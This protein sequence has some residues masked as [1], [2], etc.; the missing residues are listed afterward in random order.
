[1][2]AL[3]TETLQVSKTVM[4][5]VALVSIFHVPEHLISYK[6]KRTVLSLRNNY[7]AH[8]QVVLVSMTRL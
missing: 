7:Y 8:E 1:M 6:H 4:L 2:D 5:Q 3:S